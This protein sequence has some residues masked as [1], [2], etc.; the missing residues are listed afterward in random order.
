[1]KL[2]LM[3]F[4]SLDGVSQGPGGPEEDRSGGFTRGGW[5]V[6]F[7]DATFMQTITKWIEPVDAL[8][9]GR[10]TY[11]AFAKHWPQQTDPGD[12]VA[13]KLNGVPKYIVS[14]TL[15]EATWTPT[16][17]LAKDIPARIAQIKR[18]AGR[19]IQIHG[20]ATLAHSLLTEGLVDEVR[21]VIAPV[22][23]GQGRKLFADGG[24]PLGFKL[25]SHDKT[26]TGLVIHI[27]QP[28]GTPTFATYGVA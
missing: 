27:Y 28:T 2:V 7:I 23:I 4:V 24:P 19:E 20:S 9:F 10:R 13:K 11:E 25:V 17:I 8:L 1:M 18:Q 16:T 3:Q 5:F 22:I 6:P 26:P 14:K 12:I 15:P 21:L